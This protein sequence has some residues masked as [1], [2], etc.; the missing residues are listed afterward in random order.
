MN[1]V[2]KLAEEGHKAAA[3]NPQRNPSKSNNSAVP[4]GS[5]T[6]S[7]ASSQVTSLS[8]GIDSTEYTSPSKYD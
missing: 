8:N 4:V 6:S 7:T 5:V 1:L 2:R 3:N